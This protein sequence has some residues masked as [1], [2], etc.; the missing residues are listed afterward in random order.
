MTE[1][2]NPHLLV[3]L[4]K[5]PELTA[6]V[7]PADARDLLLRLAPVV[8]GLRLAATGSRPARNGDGTPERPDRL[9]TIDQAAPL[10]ALSVKAL[11]ARADRLPFTRHLGRGTLRF[12]EAGLQQ[13]LTGQNGVDNRSRRR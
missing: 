9:L 1:H 5:A 8:E 10:L 13:W 6:D 2:T 3:E 11:Y 4:V 12:S 7:S